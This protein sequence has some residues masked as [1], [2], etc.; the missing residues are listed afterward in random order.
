MRQL[1]APEEPTDAQIRDVGRARDVQVL[2]I[3][4]VLP[5]DGQGLV[6]AVVVER[7]VLEGAQV[8]QGHEESLPAGCLP[9]AR[10]AQVQDLQLCETL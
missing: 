2:E 4:A 3:Q 9:A 6:D 7:E 5:E 10:G 8:L 1:T